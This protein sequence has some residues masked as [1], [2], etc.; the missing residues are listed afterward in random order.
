MTAFS[1]RL[2]IVPLSVPFIWEGS[3]LRSAQRKRST[4]HHHHHHFSSLAVSKPQ[5]RTTHRHTRWLKCTDYVPHTFLTCI[6]FFF[7][8]PPPVIDKPKCHTANYD[9]EAGLIWPNRETKPVTSSQTAAQDNGPPPSSLVPQPCRS[10]V[11]GQKRGAG[12]D[13]C[14]TLC[15]WVHTS[16]VCTSVEFPTLTKD[17]TQLL[18]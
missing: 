2:P 17:S 10:E 9:A 16:C 6:G 14:Q 11:T 18:A 8:R 13:R 7:D 5:A 12:S 3:L 15:T 4:R 1:Q